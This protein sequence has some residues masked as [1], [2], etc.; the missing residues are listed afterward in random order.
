MAMAAGTRTMS[1]LERGS[2]E[3]ATRAANESAG[4]QTR[5]RGG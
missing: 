1:R 2:Q 4:S 3:R 5:Y